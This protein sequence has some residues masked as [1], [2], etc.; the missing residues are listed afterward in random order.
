LWSGHQI[1]RKL[2]EVG[3]NAGHSALIFLMSANKDIDFLIFDINSHAYTA[4][5]LE[6]LKSSFPGVKYEFVEGDSTVT[7]PQ[8]I[9]ANPLQAETFDV[10]HMDGGHSEA[11]VIE[12]LKNC[13]RLVRPGGL[14]IVDDTNLPVIEKQTTKF[15]KPELFKE[16]TILETKRFCHRIFQKL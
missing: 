1:G 10:V 12:D 5:C 9:E 6:Y 2:C 4:P 3:F 15:M 7:I 14:L 13:I 16:V 8:W 11:V